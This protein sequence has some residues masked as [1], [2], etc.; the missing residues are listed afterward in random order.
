[1]TLF[2]SSIICI[3]FLREDL[4]SRSI[5]IRLPLSR[6]FFYSTAPVSGFILVL[7]AI[8]RFISISC[9]NRYLFRNNRAFQTD[10]MLFYVSFN[11]VAYMLLAFCKIVHFKECLVK[12]KTKYYFSE[13]FWLLWC[14]FMYLST[15]LRI[16]YWHFAKLYILKNA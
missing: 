7:V 11:F 14:Y 12:I 9:P 10:L 3:S 5:C 8:D 2:S 15:S 4:I 16:C 1:M 13:R 6:F